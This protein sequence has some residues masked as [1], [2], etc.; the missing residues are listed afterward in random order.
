[1]G[2]L[3]EAIEDHWSTWAVHGG[4]VVDRLLF[5]VDRAEEVA[6]IVSDWCATHL[7]SPVTAGHRWMTSVGSVAVVDL[8]DGRTVVVKVHQ[9][10][11]SPRFLR[12]V[13]AVQGAVASAGIACPQ[14]IAAPAPIGPTGSLAVADTVLADPGL[15]DGRAPGAVVAAAT[16]LAAAITAAESIDV[17]GLPAPFQVPPGHLWPRPHSPVF[18]F[19]A[20]HVGAEWIDALA[21]RAREVRDRPVDERACVAHTDW[22]SRNVRV[23]DGTVVAAYDWDAVTWVTPSIAVGQAAALWPCTGEPDSPPASSPTELRAFVDAYD[24]SAVTPLCG[25]PGR[26]RT[27]AAALYTLAYSARCEHAIGRV[28]GSG[29]NALREH[30]DAYL[31]ALD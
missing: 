31:H 15:T 27:G 13:Q 11:R 21:R 12:A 17:A 30:G 25:G 1:M 22:C 7:G 8:A 5:G 23:V 20:T 18:D 28:D 16:T 24:E 26:R 29:T 2:T 4:P 3:A 14:P 6:A 10:D 9:P 19:E